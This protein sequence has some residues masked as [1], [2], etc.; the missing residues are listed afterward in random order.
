MRYIKLENNQPMEYTI[1]QLLTDYPNAKIYK[2]SKM[3]NEKLLA[4]FDVYPLI[5]EAKPIVNQD[6]TVEESIPNFRDGEWH[7]TWLV[8]KLTGEEIEEIIE[9]SVKPS[10]DTSTENDQDGKYFFATKEL[11]EQRYTICNNCP[12][13]TR[14]KTCKECGCIMPLKI[15]LSD[16]SCPLE[17]W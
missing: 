1:E 2:K 12:A 9:M 14:L 13:F 3:P 7:Q 16:S 4:A 15:K 6:E 5:T 17:K 8:R 10:D 11:Q